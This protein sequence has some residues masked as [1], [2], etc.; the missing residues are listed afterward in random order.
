LTA[1]QTDVKTTLK[2]LILGEL[3]ER[4]RM[5]DE[6]I[7]DAIDEIYRRAGMT[8]PWAELD[9]AVWSLVFGRRIRR[10]EGKWEGEY[11]YTIRKP[12]ARLGKG[13]KVLF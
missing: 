8:C 7:S 2:R 9:G 6:Q 1:Q 11:W 13:Q 5:N 4:G 10:T 12:S 3:A